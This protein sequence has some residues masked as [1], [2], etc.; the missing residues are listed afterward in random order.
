M[1]SESGY[2][3]QYDHETVAFLAAA[4]VPVKHLE[5]ADIGIRGNGHF[6]F[7]EKNSNEIAGVVREWLEMVVDE[8]QEAY[9]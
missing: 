1:T 4:G 5:L 3:V 9:A 6:M 7:L 8:K 2:H